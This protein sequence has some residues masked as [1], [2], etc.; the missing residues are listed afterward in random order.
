M[1]YKG[2][3]IEESLEDKKVLGDAKI[4]STKVGVVSEKHQTPWLK[5]WTLH[6]VEIAED[7]AG[8]I[9]EEISRVLDYSHKSAWYADF[10]NDE[11][12]YIIFKN[13]IFKIGRQDGPGYKQAKDYGLALGIPAHQVDFSSNS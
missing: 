8:K 10:K 2:T 5:Q 3:I 1:N 4:L 13:K 12:H 7:K 9:A 11:W 6:K